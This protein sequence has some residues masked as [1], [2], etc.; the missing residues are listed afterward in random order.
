MKNDKIAIETSYK[1][2]ITY[3]ELEIRIN[4]TYRM[5]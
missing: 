2:K 5:D 3:S 1:E 4:N